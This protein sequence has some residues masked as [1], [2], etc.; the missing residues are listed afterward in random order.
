MAI[1]GK[2][3]VFFL[4]D[5]LGSVRYRTDDRGQITSRLA[6]TPFGVPQQPPEPHALQPAF[7]G[8]FFDPDT[9]LYIT[10][11][12]R[13]SPHLGRFV[14]VDPQHRIPY[15]S[16]AD[17]SPYT[18]SGNDP[19]NYV[20]RTGAVR[21][22][23]NPTCLSWQDAIQGWELERQRQIS[24]ATANQVQMEA[25]QKARD[26]ALDTLDPLLKQ[27]GINNRMLS[28][29]GIDDHILKYV[30]VARML[31]EAFKEA[32][33]TPTDTL[34]KDDRVTATELIQKLSGDVQT[35]GNAGLLSPE[36]VKKY[37]DILVKADMQAWAATTRMLLDFGRT[38]RDLHNVYRQQLGL[39]PS[40]L[41]MREARAA[42]V[43]IK[44]AAGI[45]A[46]ALEAPETVTHYIALVGKSMMAMNPA[47]YLTHRT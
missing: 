44:Q 14:Q 20:D 45:F 36:Q 10:P 18:Y 12:R 23:V 28:K 17:L 38:A 27:L 35:A 22:C 32:I 15:G 43:R 13:Y 30:A 11:G 4:H 26:A 1:T 8:L 16:P 34:I 33:R 19:V 46:A 40:N 29:L 3:V 2:R 41:A 9:R 24:E 7:A 42:A 39:G 37:L 25:L 21:E 47:V 5:H 31:R 6:Y